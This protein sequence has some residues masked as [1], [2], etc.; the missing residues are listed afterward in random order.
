[1]QDTQSH[2]AY[3]ITPPTG[4]AE[5]FP[6]DL[7]RMREATYRSID[8]NTD[9][10]MQDILGDSLTD[11]E[12]M[13]GLRIRPGQFQAR[14]AVRE[15]IPEDQ[16]LQAVQTGVY[17]QSIGAYDRLKLPGVNC[18]LT[19]L[20][21]LSKGVRTDLDYGETYSDVVGNLWIEPPD[22]GWNRDIYNETGTVIVAAFTAGGTPET[23]VPGVIQKAV[24][25]QALYYLNDDPADETRA[26]ERSSMYA[27]RQNW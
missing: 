18:T 3:R 23:P 7:A 19:K 24:A 27:Y 14:F 17:P 12:R 2:Y 9:A 6:L 13:T 4:A 10:E 5:P 22:D 11:I 16:G 1:M 21:T 8:Q 26:R 25:L 20:E 15:R